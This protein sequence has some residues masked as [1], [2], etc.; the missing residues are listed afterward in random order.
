MKKKTIKIAHLCVADQKNKGDVAIVRAVKDLF[1]DRFA[2]IDWLDWPIEFL[3]QAD[4]NDLKKI[5]SCDL[6][7]LG[8]G[9]I[10][11]SYFLPF[12]KK[13]IAGIKIPLFVFGAGYIRE[14]GSS[15]LSSAQVDSLLFLAKKATLIGL[16]D[17]YSRQ[18]FLNNKI[19]RNK[20]R[21]IGDPAIFLREEKLNSIQAKK[22]RLD[23]P[24]VKIGLNLN[25]SGWLGFGRYRDDILSAYQAVIDYFVS[26]HQARIYYL[27][28][29]PGEDEIVKSLSGPIFQTV[30]LDCYRQK[31]L[32]S[33]LDLV[34]GMMLHSCVLSFGALTPEINLAY[35]L[36]NK[37]FAR[38]IACPELAFD[39]KDLKNQGLLNRVKTVYNDRV[40]YRKLF[41]AKKEAIWRYQ[42]SFLDEIEAYVRNNINC[43]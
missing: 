32:Y 2:S 10:F 3:R 4:E 34:V 37:S 36:R 11:Y 7:I 27:K 18:L 35:D 19:D 20:I 43:D 15:R 5:N 12:S 41:A 13:V 9:G 24:V 40:S 26:R 8:G 28:H 16:R 39:L 29:H 1:Q 42:S 38:F 31:Y 14:V 6:A 23:D 33:K 17:K 22:Y 25:Y 30:D 21:L